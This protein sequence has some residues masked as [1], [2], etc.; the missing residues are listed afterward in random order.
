MLRPIDVQNCEPVTPADQPAPM[1][2][3]IPIS[4]IVM[5]DDYQ[6]EL[7]PNNWKPDLSKWGGKQ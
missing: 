5:D 6:R 3:W 4:K 2:D 1:L 7:K